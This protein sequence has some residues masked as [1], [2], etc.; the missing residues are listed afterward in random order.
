MGISARL[1][2][3]D[4]IARTS[5]LLAIGYGPENIEGAVAYGQLIRVRKGWYAAKDVPKAA[6]EACRVGG[7]LACVS[8][9]AYHGVIPDERGPL[10]VEVSANASRLRHSSR[11]TVL[12]WAVLPSHGTRQAVSL[13]AAVAQAARC[14]AGFREAPRR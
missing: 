9:L 4:G 1:A 2:K 13:A 10:H 8:A 7:R 12:H 14:R 5:E 6:I 11:G 3:F